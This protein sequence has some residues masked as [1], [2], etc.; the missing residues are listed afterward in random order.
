MIQFQDLKMSNEAAT[1]WANSS[2]DTK[3]VIRLAFS[4]FLGTPALIA[5]YEDL[6]VTGGGI[7]AKLFRLR[8]GYARFLLMFLELIN[9]FIVLDFDLQDGDNEH[10]DR[11]PV[12]A[13]PPTPAPP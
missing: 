10:L 5:D 7:N 3:I 4:N 13:L 1:K 11:S 9:E 8:I 6:S 12:A 2:I